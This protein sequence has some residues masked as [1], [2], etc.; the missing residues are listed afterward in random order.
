V[1][2]LDNKKRKILSFKIPA[3]ENILIIKRVIFARAARSAAIAVA[4]WLDGCHTPV[5]C[6]N[7]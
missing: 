6:L 7:G 2:R 1:W 4:M 5:L 3:I